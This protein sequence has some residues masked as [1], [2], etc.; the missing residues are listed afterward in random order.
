MTETISKQLCGFF[1]VPIAAQVGDFCF[2]LANCLKKICVHVLPRWLVVAPGLPPDFLEDRPNSAESKRVVN[3]K[4][5]FFSVDFCS[6]QPYLYDMRYKQT[7][8][9]L[10]LSAALDV[11]RSTWRRMVL[12]GKIPPPVSGVYPQKTAGNVDTTSRAR[13][14]SRAVFEAVGRDDLAGMVEA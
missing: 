14:D 10:T 8:T 4:E 12:A 3:K 11:S 7:E 1:V 13:W 5:K 9:L 2:V 6:L